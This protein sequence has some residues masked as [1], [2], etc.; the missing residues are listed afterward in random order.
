MTFDLSGLVVAFFGGC[1]LTS[2]GFMF[3][4]GN[5]LS[6]V[7]EALKE[8]KTAVHASPCS[9][10]QSIKIDVAVLDQ[11]VAQLEAKSTNGGN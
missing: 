3:G 4:Y 11:R 10:S 7:E 8:V 6:K 9:S 2:V 5:R 1:A